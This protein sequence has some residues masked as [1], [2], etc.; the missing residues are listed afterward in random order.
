[1][2]PYLEGPLWSTVHS[3][4]IEEIA[5]QLAPKLRP[6][7]LALS[8]QRV[9]VAAPDPVEF[10]SQTRF[11]DVGVYTPSSGEAG[12]QSALLVSPLV[13]KYAAP[14]EQPQTFLEIR[15]VAEQRLVTALEVLSPT[16]KRGSGL[17]DFS[18]KRQELLHG[19]AHYIEIDLLRI[20][21]RFPMDGTLPAAPYFVFLS[22]EA[23]PEIPV[24]LL[25]GDAD[26]SIDLQRAFTTIYDLFGYDAAVD[27]QG[28]PTVPLPA[29]W[30][31]WA[32]D[33][34]R[35]AGI[36]PDVKEG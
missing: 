19:E 10:P 13:M 31:R 36:V 22:N 11:P 9:V 7:Y 6:K 17:A 20:G 28:E 35:A 29:E 32:R 23:L 21:Q 24:P 12:G 3:N 15:D 27:H 16:N 1:M 33:R 18:R 8:N 5:R 4:L 25:Q 30:A 34:V 26:V 2:D 14:E